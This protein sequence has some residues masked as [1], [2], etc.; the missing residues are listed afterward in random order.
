MQ[1]LDEII[2][3][4]KTANLTILFLETFY[5]IRKPQNEENYSQTGRW[6]GMEDSSSILYRWID[7]E[8]VQGERR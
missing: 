5:K 1:E 4:V 6:V 2:E 8:P 7:N 3:E